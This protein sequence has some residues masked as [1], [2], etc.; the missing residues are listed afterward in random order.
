MWKL[1]QVE[2]IRGEFFHCLLKGV[3]ALFTFFNAK[4][5]TFRG[6]IEKTLIGRKIG[7]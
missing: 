7:A 3:S 1:V 5:I 6:P 2:D 4:L